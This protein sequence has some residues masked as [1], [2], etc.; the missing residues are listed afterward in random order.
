[1]NP[2]VREV[3]RSDYIVVTLEHGGTIVRYC[4]QPTPFPDLTAAQRCYDEVIAT[5]DRIG[6]RGRGILVD[7][8]QAI[9]RNDQAFEALLVEFRRRALPG[10]AGSAVLMRT[11]VGLLQAQRI[12]RNQRLTHL[13]TDDEAEAIAF[14]QQAVATA[15]AR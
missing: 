9:G 15:A 14:L 12:D 3:Y 10:F 13:V 6:R 7:S 1:M 2:P 5:Y 8:R 11:A 4:R